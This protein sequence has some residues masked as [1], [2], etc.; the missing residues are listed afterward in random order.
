M[1][2][3]LKCIYK[4][5][6]QDETNNFIKNSTSLWPII[7]MALKYEK[8]VFKQFSW[9]F[10]NDPSIFS[11]VYYLQMTKKVMNISTGSI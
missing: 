5:S 8:L 10:Y 9:Q 3:K 6:R 1:Y 2:F 7:W 11:N 4:G